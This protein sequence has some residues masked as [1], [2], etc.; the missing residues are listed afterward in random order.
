MATSS[1][2][3]SLNDLILAYQTRDKDSAGWKQQLGYIHRKLKEDIHHPD[4]H[5]FYQGICSLCMGDTPGYWVWLD[6]S[7]Q[8]LKDD[9]TSRIDMLPQYPDY[10]ELSTKELL[11]KLESDENKI[12]SKQSIYWELQSRY[13]E[14]IDL[15]FDFNQSTLKEIK[16]LLKDVID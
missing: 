7:L 16:I 5:M 13:P 6:S 9:P 11:E 3:T 1:T 14:K 10:A 2:T 15:N 8:K 4:E 12:Y